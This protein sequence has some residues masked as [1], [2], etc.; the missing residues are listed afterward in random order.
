MLYFEPVQNLDIS[1]YCDFVSK[2]AFKT[3]SCEYSYA[4]IIAWEDIYDTKFSIDNEYI[5][6]KMSFDNS[7]FY[8]G[9][10]CSC[11]DTEKTFLKIAHA[12]KKSGENEANFICLTDT[13]IK[14]LKYAFP[15]AYISQDTG[16][17]CDYIYETD[18]L[19]TF[20]GKALHSKRNHLNKFLSLYNN[21]FRYEKMTKDNSL[22]CLEFNNKWYELNSEY[23][24]D[25]ERIATERLLKNFDRLNLLGGMLYIDN[26]LCAYTISSVNPCNKEQLIIH[27][28]KGFYEYNGIYPAIC[29]EF[30]KQQDSNIKYVNREDDA[31]DEGLKKSKLSYRPTFF[32]NK[33]TAKIFF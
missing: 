12:L 27:A 15:K 23:S 13:H 31:G 28:E 26:L 10:V 25:N 19:S 32:E 2:Y 5:L 29:S 1:K 20:S 3:H 24:L 33:Y 21:R 7:E 4:N 11:S 14:A 8:L 17:M 16:N 30:L 9:P 18:K 6:F 22:L